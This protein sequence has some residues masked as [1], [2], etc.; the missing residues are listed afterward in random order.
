MEEV[1]CTIRRAAPADAVS[2]ANLAARTF[3]DTFEADNKREDMAEHLA[4]SYGPAQQ[5]A[6]IMS[7]AIITLLASCDGP[8]A[9]AQL[10]HG[11]PPTCVTSE[12]PIELWRFYVD[13][14]WH[15]R[16][17]AKLLM[18]SVFKEAAATG[19][20]AVWL[21]VWER[22]PRAIAFYRKFGFVDVGSH[23]FRLGTDVQTD[24]IM[25]RGVET[26]DPHGPEESSR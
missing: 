19:A 20:A 21:G 3:R 4:R 24:R 12:R 22:N 11:K 2:L 8:A 25:V 18:Q 13:R 16:G 26:G 6:E 23:E 14:E 17:V 7:P 15:G 10:R 5:L 9:F 1:S